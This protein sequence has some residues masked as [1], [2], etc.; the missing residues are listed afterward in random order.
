[1]KFAILPLCALFVSAFGSLRA[2][3][4]PIS[5]FD[6]EF[7]CTNVRLSPDGQY[8]GFVSGVGQ[9]GS[10]HVLV[11]MNLATKETKM[12]E[13]P[14]APNGD[15]DHLEEIRYF[16]W[17]S[18][19][20]VIFKYA[21]PDG[22]LFG[23]GAFDRDGGGWQDFPAMPDV[24]FYSGDSNQFLVLGTYESRAHPVVRRI[25]SDPRPM[26]SAE[27]ARMAMAAVGMELGDVVTDNEEMNQ[28]VVDRVGR[29]RLGV[30]F[31]GDDTRVIYRDN[32]LAPW[33][34]L[35]DFEFHGPGGYPMAIDWDGRTAYVATLTRYGTWGVSTYD[36]VARKMGPLIAADSTYDILSPTDYLANRTSL[37]FSRK[38][39][40]LIGIR[41]PASVYKTAWIDPEMAQLQVSL[42]R[43]FPGS[44]NT[45]TDWSDDETKILF[46][47]WS[48]RQPP[49]YYLLDKTTRQIHRLFSSAPWIKPSLMGKT[50][51]LSYRAR[52]GLL[53]HGYVT[54]P[55]DSNLKNLPLVVVPNSG[56]IFGR[57][58]LGY[59]PFIQ[60][61]ASRGY[62]VLQLNPRGS[63][64]YGEA[65]FEAGRRQ[66]GKGVQNDLTDGVLWAIGRGIADPKRIAIVGS[67]YG[68]FCAEWGLT[69]TP[70]L[71]RC[72]VSIAGTS[73]WLALFR[74]YDV[75]LSFIKQG[76]YEQVSDT[77]NFLEKEVG[78]P[79]KDAAMLRD[80]SPINHVDRVKAPV[81]IITA[82][83]EGPQ[84]PADQ[85]KEFIAALKARGAA[86]EVKVYQRSKDNAETTQDFLDFLSL[87]E[88]FLAKNMR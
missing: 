53:I 4:L 83:K 47:S 8:V 42:D 66:T 60:F 31:D 40:R 70:D 73:D 72:G 21:R 39:Q 28:W 64:G 63:P 77:F 16:F 17:L 2:E 46:S 56:L 35:R 69:N 30:A 62:A 65:F 50:F 25:N 12:F 45:I 13:A 7:A 43:A 57:T 68:G 38:K 3:L 85:A 32:D 49:I 14:P 22:T 11:L 24:F 18:P 51:P 71:Y 15:D 48:D 87:V 55:P 27:K 86:Y 19:K 54:F 29:V 26:T 58:V 34:R 80:I 44:F 23:L 10:H 76:G 88:T 75:G 61:L 67:N 78:D 5:D 81:L 79:R 74:T 1:L 36:L 41:Y 84:D 20:R 6:R 59:D 52:D 37:L 9:K 82:E 33:T